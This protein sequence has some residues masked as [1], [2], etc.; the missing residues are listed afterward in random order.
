MLGVFQAS[1]SAQL[2]EEVVGR[3]DAESDL[4]R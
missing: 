1:Q 2:L 4:D 3:F